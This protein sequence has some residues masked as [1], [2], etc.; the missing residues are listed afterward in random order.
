MDGTCTMPISTHEES[1]FA[2]A[3]L[4]SVW[5]GTLVNMRDSVAPESLEMFTFCELLSSPTNDTTPS[6]IKGLIILH[7]I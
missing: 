1:T 2:P 3:K 6:E 7:V 5:G 4:F